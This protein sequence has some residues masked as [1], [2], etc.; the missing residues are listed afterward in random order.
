LLLLAADPYD[1][2]ILGW[3]VTHDH[4]KQAV[5]F[6][7]ERNPNEIKDDPTGLK[8]LDRRFVQFNGAFG[9]TQLAW[10]DAQLTEADEACVYSLSLPSCA[11]VLTCRAALTFRSGQLAFI[12]C[13]VPFMPGAC[14][15]IALVWNF[16][17]A[18]DVLHK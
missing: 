10:L 3:P 18:L 12:A 14:D 7:N 11:L 13:H 16:Q 6:I 2:S 15:P 1:I 5:A 17:D 9:K 4:Q 8:G